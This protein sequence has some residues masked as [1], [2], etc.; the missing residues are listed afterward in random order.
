MRSFTR[1]ALVVTLVIIMLMSMA[2]SGYAI[3]FIG[4]SGTG[5]GSSGIST[6]GYGIQ[7]TNAATNNVIGWRFTYMNSDGSIFGNY[8]KDDQSSLEVWINTLGTNYISSNHFDDEYTMSLFYE[9]RKMSKIELMDLDKNAGAGRWNI[10]SKIVG[11]DSTYHGIKLYAGSSVKAFTANTVANSKEKQ[12]KLFKVDGNN[13]TLLKTAP[14]NGDVVIMYSGGYALTSKEATS[15]YSYLAKYI[16]CVAASEINDTITVTGDMAQFTVSVDA[17]GYYTFSTGNATNNYLSMNS[18][19][20]GITLEAAESEYSKWVLNQADWATTMEDNVSSAKPDPDPMATGLK[21][22][23]R[24]DEAAR[25]GS[26]KESDVDYFLEYGEGYFWTELPYDTAKIKDWAKIN[27]NMDIIIKCLGVKEGVAGMGYGDRIIVEPVFFLKVSNCYMAATPTEIAIVGKELAEEYPYYFMYSNYGGSGNSFGAVK[28]AS[29]TNTDNWDWISRYTNRLFPL[30][31]YVDTSLV[32]EDAN[33]NGRLLWVAASGSPASPDFDSNRLRITADTIIHGGYGVG[34]AFAMIQGD[35]PDVIL[36]VAT[37]DIKLYDEDGNL[38][39]PLNLIYGQKVYAK[40]R[41][42][43]NSTCAVEVNCYDNDGL[44][45]NG[46]K[47]SLNGGEYIV[48]QGGSFTVDWLGSSSLTGKVL[49][50]GVDI[51][52]ESNTANNTLT[53]PLNAVFDLEISAITVMDA[54]GVELDPTNLPFGETIY[55]YHTYRNNSYAPIRANGYYDNNTPVDVAGSTAF[56]LN[57]GQSITVLA[58]TYD[59]KE[60]ENVQKSF[61][62]RIYRDGS[63]MSTAY[64]WDNTNNSMTISTTTEFDIAITEIYFANKEGTK[65]DHRGIS[66]G[67][68]VVVHH[69]YKNYSNGDIKVDSY[70]D[71]TLYKSTGTIPANG[72]LDVAVTELIIEAGTY[73]II[74]EVYREGKTSTTETLETTLE[75]NRTTL[76]Y[77]AI[78]GAPWL[79]II[80]PNK[81]YREGTEV[82][83]SYYLHNESSAHFTEDSNLSVRMRVYENS[84][85]RL[86]YIT[87]KSVICPANEQQLVY[88]KWDV[89][90]GITSNTITIRADL[91]IGSSGYG[92]EV[93]KEDYKRIKWSVD[94]TPDPGFEEGPPAYWD[95]P[96]MPSS[97]GYMSTWYEWTMENGVFVKTMYGIQVK[98]GVVTI[99]PTSKTAYKDEDGTYC[100]K[101]GYGF[102]VDTGKVKIEPIIDFKLPS[103]DSYTTAQYAFVRYPEFGYSEDAGCTATL[104]PFI[105]G[106]HLYNFLDYDRVHWLPIWYPKGQ[107][108]V[109]VVQ[110]DIWT[111]MGCMSVR[112][113]SN[114]LRITESMYDDWYIG[115]G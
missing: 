24:G 63:N 16:T 95:R 87:E 100:T 30:S 31:L 76:T 26:V 107:Y 35:N 8:A 111:P 14:Q 1:K 57:G 12:I 13:A 113:V 58:Q 70:H 51:S 7:D 9:G 82:V 28:A 15:T 20:N 64:E 52:Q 109:E 103:E 115:H 54:N 89:P 93:V 61:T 11:K 39:D 42:D 47:I 91:A 85:N 50:N 105:D 77:S 96:D 88:F 94:F 67:S 62:G 65:I 102:T 40:Y 72:T 71:G 38:L 44:L 4:S 37:T 90:E 84:Q 5:G 19:G 99:V 17:E 97:S 86:L 48:L 69:V 110:E 101:S 53:I 80:E 43:N 106:F 98:G 114:L 112:S 104:E 56:T 83:T 45:T 73:E 27:N 3:E 36:D 59:M 78:G 18:A 74:G 79:E 46:E 49:I 32:V 81:G 68:T 60:T 66:E 34:I 6:G 10:S 75:N 92:G 108:Y 23:S 21:A 41:Y 2:V 55:I 22:Y 25:Y 29:M 33:G